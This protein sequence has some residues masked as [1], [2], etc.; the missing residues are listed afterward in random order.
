MENLPLISSDYPPFDW[1]SSNGSA[2]AEQTQ[3]AYVAIT[4]EGA[5][6]DF[7]RLVWNDMV[8]K[9]LYLIAM[10]GST[11]DKTYTT[12]ADTLIE[13]QYGALTA[14]KFNSVTYNIEKLIGTNWKWSFDKKQIGYLGRPRVVGVTESPKNSDLVYGWY[15][16]ELVRVVNLL[17]DILKN[18]ADFGELQTDGL[19]ES[20]SDSSLFPAKSGVL[21]S[22][23]ASRSRS[24]TK[25]Y[26]AKAGVLDAVTTISHST[27]D[28]DLYK[29]KP[30]PFVVSV[31][32]DGV[33]I[34]N[35]FPAPI[36]AL[37]ANTKSKS[38]SSALLKDLIYAARL[39]FNGSSHSIVS[40]NMSF[41]DCVE[42]L[43]RVGSDSIAR[44]GMVTSQTTS[45]KVS[46]GS[47]AIAIATASCM[48]RLLID[49]KA[50]S[51]S[52]AYTDL[53]MLQRLAL[54]AEASSQTQVDSKINLP[55]A[56][57]LYVLEFSASSSNSDIAKIESLHI[58]STPKSVSI[59]DTELTIPLPKKMEAELLSKSSTDSQ[60]TELLPKH[61]AAEHKSHSTATCDFAV[62]VPKHMIADIYSKSMQEATLSSVESATM[63]SRSVSASATITSLLRRASRTIFANG[64]SKS[65]VRSALTFY[66]EPTGDWRDPIQIGSNLYIT[67]AYPQWQ[68]D[69]NVR[70]DSGG[71][72]YDPIQ[73]GS[74]IY[75]RSNDSMKEV[76]NNG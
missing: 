5:T 63:E 21:E 43:V 1:N 66:V 47:D 50:R 22:Q 56:E 24:Y 15:I 59:S 75:I 13:E 17:I 76:V 7:S 10:A 58:E 37:K 25:L 23:K 51:D 29:A 55:L 26:P 38:Y 52:L 11:W 35:L 61:L 2:T 64:V 49:A 40:S 14:R 31:A 71:V 19:S 60:I 73:T 54:F 67:S 32:S 3:K 33:A 28:A 70:L 57:L 20:S 53:S 6:S 48:E 34:A 36:G 39:K 12:Y 72:F 44:A 9:V 16:E 8:G 27:K 62:S 74:D 46:V 41:R 42:A 68:E 45:L 4:S 18:E 65:K 30:A 69:S